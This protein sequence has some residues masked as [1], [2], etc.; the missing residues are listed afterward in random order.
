MKFSLRLLVLMLVALVALNGCLKV[1][2]VVNINKDGSGTI[3]ELILIKNMGFGQSASHNVETLKS[4]AGKYGEGVT[5]KTSE[6]MTE[7]EMSGYKV[8]YSFNDINK[9]RLTDDLTDG[10]FNDNE[11]LDSDEL[12]E[13]NFKKGSKATLDIVFPSEPEEE[14]EEEDDV[15]YEDEPEVSE[16]EMAQAKEMMKEM[17]KDMSMSFILKFDGKIV[18]TDATFH[19][20]NQVA[21]MDFDFSKILDDE[22][23]LNKLAM[24]QSQDEE[25]ML[26]YMQNTP[27]IKF[28]NKD[29]ITVEFK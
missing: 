16:E 12:I 10:L 28:E 22:E 2:R 19:D 29:K 24:E 8:V 1:H 26:E 13:F 14:F 27:G 9:L 15:M 11:E 21:L 20:G 17:Y 25:E 5:Y 4:A 3:E 6:A 18:S 23:L 7:N